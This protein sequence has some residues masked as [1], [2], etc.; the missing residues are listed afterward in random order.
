MVSTA[1][2]ADTFVN[3]GFET[4]SF[5]NWTKG[6]GTVSTSGNTRIFTPTGTGSASAT[7]DLIVTNTVSGQ[8]VIN[9][10]DANTLGNLCEVY[11]GTYA[12]R[13]NN[14]DNGS[15][16]NYIT[17]QVTGYQNDRI[18]FAWAAVLLDP[19]NTPHTVVQEPY[20][21]ITVTDNTTST[22]LYDISFDTHF[23]IPAAGFHDGLVVGNSD[24]NNSAGIWKYT[25]WNPVWLNVT[26]GH[27]FTM[28]VLAADC[29]LGGH[30][31]Y[32]YVDAF[33][34]TELPANPGVDANP[35]QELGVP[36]PAAIS[37][38]ALG[39]LVIF[40]RRK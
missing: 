30:G 35:I 36:E 34:N 11:N 26:T 25:D 20:F 23:N 5:S 2:A 29:T 24:P 7:K 27:D 18:Y 37:L 14:F 19:T 22:I 15:H 4:G 17:Q 12:A 21:H 38:L 31:G 32:A 1:L 39:S 16:Y 8:T 10:K 40:R 3:G 33:N 6:Y 9:S 13:V 28:T